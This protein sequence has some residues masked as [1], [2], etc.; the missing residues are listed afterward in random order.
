MSLP[1]PFRGIP[2]AAALVLCCT[3][4]TLT[5][6]NAD[7]SPAVVAPPTVTAPPAT[8]AVTVDPGRLTI[9]PDSPLP[10]IHYPR[11]TGAT[12]GRWFLFIIP[13][14]GQAPLTYSAVGLPP[15]LTL[16][17]HTGVI[18]GSLKSA[19]RTKAA[20]TVKNSLGVDQSV[21]TIVGGDHVLAQTPPM[22]WNSWNVWAA[23]VD[24]NKVEAAADVISSTG[25]TQHGY[26]Y[27]N[28]D[29]TW[30]AGRDASGNIQPN[31]KFPDMKALTDYVHSKGLKVGIYSSPGPK[32]CA[33]YT[34]SYQHE[35]QDA[36]SYAQWGF[37]Y[38]KYDW[39]TYRLV[40][41]AHPTLAD[42]QKPYVVMREALDATNRDIVYSLCQY[43]MG[44][45][46]NWGAD[47]EIKGNSW[48][49]HTD[50][51]DVWVENEWG[52]RGLYAIIESMIGLSSH[53][54]PGHWNDPDMLMVGYVGF[55]NPHPSRLT[56]N[57]QITHIS[58]WC[59]F[60]SPLLIGCDLTRLDPFTRALLTN[61]EAIAIDQDELGI[62][63]QL[64]TTTPGNG[65]I[66]VRPLSDGSQA[67][68]LFN[69]SLATLSMTVTWSE[70]GLS[71]N[72]NVRDLWLHQTLG[73]CNGSYSV[74]VPSHGTVLLKISPAKKVG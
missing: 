54:G 64:Y 4:L 49:T 33:E 43:G 25:L 2:A 34:A 53:A 17:S 51:D 12:P 1:R 5:P 52:G 67:V 14:S 35:S 13:A 19:G 69:P 41:P 7:V 11:I 62:P 58:M 59:M 50:I 27:V 72:Q 18:T 61:D 47:P 23:N 32:T 55:G 74:D 71:G 3:S 9:P 26:E 70:L 36:A 56:P 68:A 46:W 45:V 63:A 40:A 37:D 39:C 28:I 38:L 29:D 30:E 16:N 15:G 21:L 66:W 24:E 8:Q 48:R 44:D 22:G 42:Y 6:S 31:A 10:A 60:S 65:E 73:L 20:I 57:E